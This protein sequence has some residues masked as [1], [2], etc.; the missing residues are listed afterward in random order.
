VSALRT[1]W[2]SATAPSPSCSPPPPRTSS[3]SDRGA[4]PK[5]RPRT[6]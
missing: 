1:P 5:W 6:T 4:V 3:S 2:S